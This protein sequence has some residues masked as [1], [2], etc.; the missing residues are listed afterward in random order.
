[1]ATIAEVAKR[2]GAST[3]TVSNVIRGTVRV[4]P[5]L[6]ARVEAAIRELDFHPN[7]IA[8]SLKVNQTYMLGM[9][10]PDVTNPFF[11]QIMRGAEDRALE[12]G[13]LLVTANTDE[14]IERERRVVSALRS[15][16]VDGI[17]LTPTHG[18][19]DDQIRKTIDSGIPIVCLDRSPIGM[20]IDAVMLDNVRG[21]QDCVRHLIRT[22][23]STIA[24]ITGPLSLGIARERLRGYEEGLKEGGVEISKD[25]ILEGDFREKSGYRLAKQLLLQFARP[26]AI[27]VSNGVMALG[28]LQ[29]FEELGVR[30][31]DDV[32]LATFDELAGDRAF[33]PRLTVIA[34]PGYE[35]GARGATLLM[36]R[37]EGKITK[38][39]SVIR[40]APTLIVR[41]S[42]RPRT[43]PEINSL[44]RNADSLQK[45]ET[46]AF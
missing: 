7:E 11:P 45:R 16:R 38:K 15:R 8:R 5:G 1:M 28:V 32:A 20:K 44:V 31:P 27:L 37:I 3:G 33:H 35:M 25:L 41:E 9:V 23:Y 12:R 34:Q 14:Q 24:I 13:F 43:S 46:P 36:D 6:R 10:L 22:G 29:A 18:K 42:T 39:C 21:A 26:S 19:D 30:C 40:V 17:L 4:S 2:A